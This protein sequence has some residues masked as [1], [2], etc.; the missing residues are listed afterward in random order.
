M[1]G[2]QVPHSR[3]VFRYQVGEQEADRH[4]LHLRL[5]QPVDGGER[6]LL[7][8]WG[9]DAAVAVDPFGDF[10]AQVTAHER[11][12]AFDLQVVEVGPGLTAD[13]QQVPEAAGSE[14]AGAGAAVLD[15]RVG[16]HRG[17]VGQVDH[18]AGLGPAVLQGGSECCQ[19]ALRRLGG[20]RWHLDHQ[21]VTAVFVEQA[22]IGKSAADIDAN[23]QS[24]HRCPRSPCP[25]L[26]VENTLREPGGSPR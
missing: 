10:Q 22:E 25:I 4:R 14:Q 20:C 15:E 26:G 13:F 2:E 1:L 18:F 7:A 19:D 23:A 12:R 8:Q 21:H 16:G 6:L 3:F 11:S 9:E 5:A 24:R 17:A